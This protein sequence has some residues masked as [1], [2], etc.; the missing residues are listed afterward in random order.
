M[1]RGVDLRL[2]DG[3][4]DPY[5]C[6]E[7]EDVFPFLSHLFAH[8]ESDDCDQDM[9]NDSIRSLQEYLWEHLRLVCPNADASKYVNGEN[10]HESGCTGHTNGESDQSAAMGVE[11]THWR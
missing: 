2:M 7:C 3:E 11:W 10:G 8:I 6:P 5:V 1:L 4:V 9:D